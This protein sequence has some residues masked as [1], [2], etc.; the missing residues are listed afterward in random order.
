MLCALNH[1]AQ[2]IDKPSTSIL[3]AEYDRLEIIQ[4]INSGLKRLLMLEIIATKGKTTA[5]TN[6]LYLPGKRCLPPGCQGL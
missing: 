5:N 1:L 6:K 3:D 4:E 2:S